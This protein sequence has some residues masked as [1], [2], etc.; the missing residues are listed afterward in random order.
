M[1]KRL[2]KLLPNAHYIMGDFDLLRESPSSLIGI[3]APIVSTKLEKSEEKKDYGN[4]LVPRG[5]ADIFFPTDFSLLKLM[6][7]RITNCESERMKS[8]EFVQKYSEKNWATTKSGYNP[9]KEDFFNTSF[10]LS[11]A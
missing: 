3:N 1:L 7:S 6:H 2:K 4:Y 5:S 11:K 10:F 8:F 9:L